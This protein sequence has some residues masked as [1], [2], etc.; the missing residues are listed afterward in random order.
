[1]EIM[2]ALF[3]GIGSWS[4]FEAKQDQFA[5][6]KQEA[7]VE[8]IKVT[9]AKI[10]RKQNQRVYARGSYYAHEG[11]YISNL[12]PEPQ[13]ADGCNKPVLT[14][15]LS[16]PYEGQVSVTSVEVGCQ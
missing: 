7:V 16:K 14:A 4:W 5:A 3:V 13:L 9:K 15:D 1:M 10:E 11:Y 12:S 2:L 6:E 8:A